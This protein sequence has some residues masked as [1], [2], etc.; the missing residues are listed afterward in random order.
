MISKYLPLL[1][2]CFM[3]D[4]KRTSHVAAAKARNSDTNLQEYPL[5]LHCNVTKTILQANDNSLYDYDVI[6]VIPI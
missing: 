3:I 4:N 5:I 1:F 2:I 6:E